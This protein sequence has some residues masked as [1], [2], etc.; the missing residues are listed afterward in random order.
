MDWWPELATSSVLGL[1]SYGI[2][3]FSCCFEPLWYHHKSGTSISFGSALSPLV[4]IVVLIAAGCLKN[5]HGSSFVVHQVLSVS[6]CIASST[7][8]LA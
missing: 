4:V 3:G 7:T 2:G 5:V 1:K 6:Q 8:L